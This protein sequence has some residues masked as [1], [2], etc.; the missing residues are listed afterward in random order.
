MTRLHHK[1]LVAVKSSARALLL[2]AAP[3]QA[4]APD[5]RRIVHEAALRRGVRPAFMQCL[6]RRE[7]SHRPWVTSP[8]GDAGLFQFQWRTWAWMS[9]AA[10]WPP[11]TSPYS[12]AAAADVAAWAI[13]HGYRHHWPPAA[14]CGR[15]W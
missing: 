5:V 12:A 6:A 4:Q 3:A 9:R 1:V 11:G 14:W 8:Y 7:S 10:G 15:A 13:A 2:R